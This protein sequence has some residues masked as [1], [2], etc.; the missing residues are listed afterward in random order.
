[1]LFVLIKFWAVKCFCELF[2]SSW[3][4]CVRNDSDLNNLHMWFDIRIR[5]D[6][7]FYPFCI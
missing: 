7:N 2:L 6:K 3:M 1:M 4:D 5:V